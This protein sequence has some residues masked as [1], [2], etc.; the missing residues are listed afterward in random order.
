MIPRV[1]VDFEHGEGFVAVPTVG[2]ENQG[3]DEDG[4]YSAYQDHVASIPERF[5]PADIVAEEREAQSGGLSEPNSKETED[6]LNRYNSSNI[7]YQAH[8]FDDCFLEATVVAQNEAVE[9]DFDQ[10]AESE[11]SA[12]G[13]SRA[14][15]QISQTKRSEGKTGDGSP[16]E[17]TMEVTKL[18]LTESYRHTP[19]EKAKNHDDLFPVNS[20]DDPTETE[21]DDD[22]SFEFESGIPR[23]IYIRN[24]VPFCESLNETRQ[25]TKS[26]LARLLRP[27]FAE[28]KALLDEND[29]ECYRQTLVT[30]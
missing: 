14:S 13:S 16:G 8:M 7:D 11:H 25:S 4:F 5:P 6:T 18:E 30:L 2:S 28:K 23:V 9:N 24:L 27:L 1:A 3:S 21:H 12:A 10:D 15:S 29:Q 19:N 22:S 20:F 26:I 17:G